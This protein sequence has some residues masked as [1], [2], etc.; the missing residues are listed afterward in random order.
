M[1]KS[2]NSS[3]IIFL[4]ILQLFVGNVLS[5]QEEIQLT[6]FTEQGRWIIPSDCFPAH[7]S[8]NRP[9]M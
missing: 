5:A 8:V 9:L 4:F 2:E 7:P 6:H 3:L 1:M